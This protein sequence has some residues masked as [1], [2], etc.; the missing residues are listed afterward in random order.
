MWEQ[1]SL[2]RHDSDPPLLRR[3]EGAWADDLP[4]AEVNRPRR[5]PDETGEDPQEGG[6]P[7]TAGAEDR[8]QRA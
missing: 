4:I 6:L 2:L 7:G 8:S 5:W 3:H 1:G